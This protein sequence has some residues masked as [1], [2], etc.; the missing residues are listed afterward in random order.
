MGV[1]WYLLM[2]LVVGV[3]A[4]ILHP[5]RE[6]MGIIMTLVIGVAGAF[7]A[8]L[9]GQI[10]GWY[11]LPNWKGFVV[12]IVVALILIVIYGRIVRKK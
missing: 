6:N 7:L 8:G 3:A 10:F 11:T 1:L 9:I 12:A 4:R 5:G 2:G